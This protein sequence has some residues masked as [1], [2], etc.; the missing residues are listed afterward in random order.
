MLAVVEIKGHQY[1]VKE[2]DKLDVERITDAKDGDKI[3]IKEVLLVSGEKVV[4]G[5]PFVE[6]ATVEIKLLSEEKGEKI[7]VFKMKAKKRY[8]KTQGHRQIYSQIEI[9]KIK[10]NNEESSKPAKKVAVKAT[11]QKA[12][13]KK[14]EPKKAKA[15]K[16]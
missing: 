5:M 12:V 8:R 4:V 10:F 1:L 3:V 15:T 13:A 14:A 2:G 9:L 6:G 16:K 7:R 11:E